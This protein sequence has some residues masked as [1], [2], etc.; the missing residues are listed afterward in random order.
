MHGFAL[1]VVVAGTLLLPLA[2]RPLARLGPDSTETF[3]YLP[4]LERT[5]TRTMPFDTVVVEQLREMRPEIVLIGDSMGGSR[6]DPTYFAS[7]LGNRNVAPLFYNATGSAFW[8]LAFKNWVLAVT[9]RPRL[10]VFFFRDDQLTDPLFRVAGPYRATLD[11]VARS[12]EARLN[13]V[14]ATRLQ[15]PLY[16]L[17]ALADEVYDQERLRQWLEPALVNAP[18]GLVA[19]HKEARTL[20]G[21]MNSEIFCLEAL[22][23]MAQADVWQAEEAT[24]DFD[25][26]VVTSVLPPLLA[27]GKM[28]GVR[29]A[30]VRV[31]RRPENNRPPVQSPALQRYVS[32]LRGY[33][34]KEGA[35]FHDDWGDPEQPLSMYADGD[36][37][38]STFRHRYTDRFLQVNAPFFR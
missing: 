18:V 23:S 38:S 36:H 10:A 19:R 8:Y 21:R 9:P 30:F 11:R 25:K 22:R 20:L 6:I 34:D 15:G 35:F 27:L 17:D 12:N 28:A 29:M 14:L 4:T 16:R 24:Y 3:S 5:R 7:Q 1:W 26:S 31:Q 2:L 33:L 13:V 32:R 37:L